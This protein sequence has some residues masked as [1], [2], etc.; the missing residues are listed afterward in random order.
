MKARTRNP[1]ILLPRVFV[2]GSNW[3][4]DSKSPRRL[5]P[6]VLKQLEGMSPGAA[7]SIGIWRRFY[8]P[9]SS[10][11][12]CAQAEVQGAHAR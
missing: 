6:V 12:S 5:G 1:A 2:A 8:L 3:P 4:I 10:V 11:S 9:R 7:T